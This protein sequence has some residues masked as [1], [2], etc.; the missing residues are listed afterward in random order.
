M[1]LLMRVHA[2]VIGAHTRHGQLLPLEVYLEAEVDLVAYPRDGPA[3]SLCELCEQSMHA[4]VSFG[5]VG[6]RPPTLKVSCNDFDLAWE[7]ES[8]YFLESLSLAYKVG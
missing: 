1:R 7:L 2:A 4:F 6:C 8:A 3:P 5:D